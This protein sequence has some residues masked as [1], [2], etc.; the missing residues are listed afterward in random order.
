VQ[1][2]DLRQR[3]ASLAEH[4]DEEL[5][6]AGR[7]LLALIV[8]REAGRPPEAERAA[9]IRERAGAALA[10]DKPE[11]RAAARAVLQLLDEPG[12]RTHR[13]VVLGSTGALIAVLVAVLVLRAAFAPPLAVAGPKSGVVLGRSSVAH[14]EI[15]S[16]AADARWLL[17]GR[18]VTAEVRR[19]GGRLSLARLRD[20]RHLVEV[21]SRSG[22]LGARTVRRFRLVVDRTPPA[23]ELPSPIAVRDFAPL[24]VSGTAG[25][26]TSLTVNGRPV[27]LTDGRFTLRFAGADL[28]TA[29]TFVAVDAAG[30][31]AATVEPVTRLP[32]QLA[33]PLRAV[34]VTA[35]GWADRSLR[36]G[37]LALIAE[38]RIN[39]VEL[40]LKDESGIVGF[41]SDVP[42][43]H[44]IGAAQPIYDL[45]AAVVMLHARGVRVIG[46]LV[47]FRDPIL[48]A[49]AWA[50]D[51]RRWVIQTPGGGPYAGYGGFTNFADEDVR[52]YQIAIALNA[53]RLGV[54]DVLYDYVRRPD[55]P[56]A[57]MRFPGLHGAPADAVVRFLRESRSALAP[58]RT[59]LGASVFGIAA[60]RPGEIAQPV[61]RMAA[62]LDYVAPMVYPSHWARGEYGVA[63][64]NAE[65]ARIVQR[66]LVDFQRAVAGTGAR[67]VPWLQDFSLGVPYGPAQVRAEIDAAR[68]DGIDEFL[69]WDPDVTYTAAALTENARPFPL[70]P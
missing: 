20:G 68:A 27:P 15:T 45:R 34:H 19:N 43:A 7:T 29:L 3:G 9:R 49:K 69:L 66:S 33:A 38:H 59:F 24:A 63:D 56:P 46:R 61:R 4:E 47:C 1:L 37:V 51:R 50:T 62:E 57:S 14:A 70:K 39:A 40:D 64:P 35:Y 28:P 23:I 58:Y 12:K 53:A 60:T 42:L 36:S 18:D 55:G 26:A 32:R 16:S 54:D 6:R 11:L 31:S 2:E 22:F 52:R 17:D 8:A 10:S 21:R 5:A 13:T 65:P 67:V 48:A 25:G 44:E 30:N 41:G